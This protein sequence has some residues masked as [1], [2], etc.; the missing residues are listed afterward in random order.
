MLSKEMRKHEIEEDLKGKGDFVQIDHLNRFLKESLSMDTKKFVYLKLAE[1]YE[2][3]SMFSDAAKMYDNAAMISITFSDKVKQYVKETELYIKAG[4]FDRADEAMK[5]AVGTASTA[6]KDRIYTSI[7]DFYKRQAEVYEKEL[8]RS[9]AVSIYE[10]VLEMKINDLERQEI[11]KK[12][13][14]LYEKLGKIKEYAAL[15]KVGLNKD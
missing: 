10:R 13:L 1:I 7:K 9:H 3:R 15:K 2:K 6:E 11:R 8:R 14:G 4:F 5:K 12:L